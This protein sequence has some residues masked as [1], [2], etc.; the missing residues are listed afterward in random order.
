MNPLLPSVHS[1]CSCKQ[2]RR[3]GIVARTH[4][5]RSSFFPEKLFHADSQVQDEELAVLKRK[6]EH[7]FASLPLYCGKTPK[8]VFTLTV[9]KVYHWRIPYLHT[10]PPSPESEGQGKRNI[11]GASNG[12]IGCRRRLLPFLVC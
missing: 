12:C 7:L 11:N 2:V 10:L 8:D 4:K 1:L 5:K 6:C 9:A 3:G